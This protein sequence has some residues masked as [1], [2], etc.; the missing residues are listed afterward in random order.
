MF[1]LKYS[2]QIHSVI[3]EMNI[4]ENKV[5]K[6]ANPV[7]WKIWNPDHAVKQVFQGSAISKPKLN[8][9]WGLV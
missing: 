6:I 8:Q 9:C 5:K 3:C 2:I 4:I 7:F 1:I